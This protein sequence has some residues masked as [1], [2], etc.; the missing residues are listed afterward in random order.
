MKRY[1]QAEGELVGLNV[2]TEPCSSKKESR[3]QRQTAY[4]LHTKSFTFKLRIE[5]LEAGKLHFGRGLYD[6][7][8]LAQKEGINETAVARAELLAC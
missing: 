1:K 2:D 3:Q 6:G 7:L 4:T 5:V 8:A